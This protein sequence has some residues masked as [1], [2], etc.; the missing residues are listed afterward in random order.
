MDDLNMHAKVDA[1]EATHRNAQCGATN[2]LAH[3]VVASTSLAGLANLLASLVHAAEGSGR[4]KFRWKVLPEVPSSCGDAMMPLQV[5]HYATWLELGVV[6]SSSVGLQSRPKEKQLLQS[7][8]C[9]SLVPF[10]P[11][12]CTDRS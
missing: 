11:L 2:Q 8:V 12:F 4:L 1:V 9:W 3:S 7:T 6:V 5:S 10:I